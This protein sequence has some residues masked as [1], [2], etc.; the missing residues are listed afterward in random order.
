MKDYLV[1]AEV[2]KHIGQGM[3]FSFDLSGWDKAFSVFNSHA[4]VK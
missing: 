1:S 4:I 2:Q 3:I